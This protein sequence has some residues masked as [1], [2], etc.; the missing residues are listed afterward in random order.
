[1][2][3]CFINT[4]WT[5]WNFCWWFINLDAPGEERKRLLLMNVAGERCAQTRCCAAPSWRRSYSDGHMVSAEH[6]RRSLLGHSLR[7]NKD[8]LG[9]GIWC[10]GESGIGRDLYVLSSV[11]K[12]I[13]QVQCWKVVFFMPDSLRCLSPKWHNSLQSRFKNERLFYRMWLALQL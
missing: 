3:D 11:H 13:Q 1:M 8:L 5:W 4:K 10:D 2:H 6:H 9:V 12:Y 7:E